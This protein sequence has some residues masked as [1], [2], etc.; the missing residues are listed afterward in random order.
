MN[1][2]LS[3]TDAEEGRLLGTYF[4][5]DGWNHRFFLSGDRVIVFSDGGGVVP[6][7]VEREAAASVVPP[8][9]YGERVTIQEIDISDPLAI[10]VLRTLSVEGRFLNA[11]SIDGTARVAPGKT[12]VAHDVAGRILALPMHTE[13]TADM[14]QRVVGELFRLLSST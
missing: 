1:G 9:E 11:R 6:M 4:L 3:I 2:R 12:D 14:Q 8:F 13:L 5:G 7:P 10:D